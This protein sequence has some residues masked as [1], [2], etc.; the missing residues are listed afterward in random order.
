[1]SYKTSIGIDIEEAKDTYK[2]IIEIQEPHVEIFCCETICSIEEAN[3][4]N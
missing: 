2:K 1:M 3:I 4:S